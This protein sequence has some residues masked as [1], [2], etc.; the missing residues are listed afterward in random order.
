MYYHVY[1]TCV[2]YMCVFW[3]S[4]IQRCY[5]SNHNVCEQEP[6]KCMGIIYLQ[7]TPFKTS[8]HSDFHAYNVWNTFLY[9]KIVFPPSHLGL[10]LL[11]YQKLLS[12]NFQVTKII[13]QQY[14]RFNNIYLN[15]KFCCFKP[16]TVFNGVCSLWFVL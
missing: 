14:L 4:V 6:C 12:K 5:A 7:Y 8:F 10:G 9:T 2:S 3:F 16:K 15:K 13:H 1:L 11:S